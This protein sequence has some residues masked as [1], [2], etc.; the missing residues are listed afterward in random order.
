MKRKFTFLVPT[1]LLA[2][3]IISCKSSGP[4]TTA[5]STK[6]Y[7]GPE[8]KL[9]STAAKDSNKKDSLNLGPDSFSTDSVKK[10]ARP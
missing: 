7:A 8:S 3:S 10:T 9:D 6:L 4:A 2:F 1:V 5:D